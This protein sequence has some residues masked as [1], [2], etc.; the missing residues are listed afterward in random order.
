MWIVHPTTV[1]QGLSQV[2]SDLAKGLRSAIADLSGVAS[3]DTGPITIA[4]GLYDA[5]PAKERYR[6]LQAVMSDRS[7]LPSTG[8]YHFDTT[9][10]GCGNDNGLFAHV[11]PQDLPNSHECGTT[12]RVA[13][14]AQG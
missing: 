4:N 8:A 3:Q 9:Q 14:R 2:G 5:I 7:P 6:R 13:H 12:Y 1:C 11:H 10:P